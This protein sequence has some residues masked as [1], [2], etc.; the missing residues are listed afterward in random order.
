MLHAAETSD[1]VGA[2]PTSSEELGA[3]S[4]PGST[5]LPQAIVNVGDSTYIAMLS[6]S[7]VSIGSQELTVGGFPTT[8]G[9]QEVNLA[10]NGV[11]VGTSTAEFHANTGGELPAGSVGQE[12]SLASSDVVVGTSTAEFSTSTGGD[13]Q[14]SSFRHEESTASQQGSAAIT[15]SGGSFSAATEGI[16]PES[17]PTALDGANQSSEVVFTAG[18]QFLTAIQSDGSVVIAGVSTTTTLAR[19]AVATIGGQSVSAQSDGSGIVV[20]SSDIAFSASFSVQAPSAVTFTAAGHTL[21]AFEA[22]G[23]VVL[24]GEGSTTT[25]PPEGVATFAGQSVSF[26]AAG[27]GIV[28]DGSSA[29]TFSAVQPVR[30]EAAVFTAGGQT[31]SAVQSGS[32]VILHDASATLTIAPN[33]LAIFEGYYN[34][35]RRGRK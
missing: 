24:A 7:I 16:L 12:V 34:Q 14:A 21:T 33:E 29:L 17:M 28:V 2:A 9:G 31:I 25:L 27:N 13:L 26:P 11:V 15:L 18:S 32:S 4:D 8:S 23:I 19:G 5:A 3:V 22:S 1:A 6:G 30:S 10:F 20:G 35:Y